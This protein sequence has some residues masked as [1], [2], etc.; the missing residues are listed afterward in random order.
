MQKAT[1]EWVKKAESDYHVAAGLQTGFK[2]SAADQICFLCQQSSEK[3]LK[4]LLEEAGQSIPKTHDLLH[5]MGLI[6]QIHPGISGLRRA[7]TVLTRYAVA[8]RYPWFSTTKRQATAAVRWS[9]KVRRACRTL[10]GIRT[11]QSGSPS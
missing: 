9:E 5:L 8:P 6:Q 3:F 4:A 10:L 11:P 1:R 7:L 2:P